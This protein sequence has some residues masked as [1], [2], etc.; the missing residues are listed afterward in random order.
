MSVTNYRHKK[1]FVLLVFIALFGV[2]YF[3]RTPSNDR[4]WSLDQQLL[5][6][7][8]FSEDEVHIFNIRNFTYQSISEYTPAYYDKKFDLNELKSVDYIVEPFG[9]MGAAHTFLSFGFNNG[10]YVAISV[11]IR[12]EVGESFSPILGLLRNYELMY[13]IA[14]ERD[15]VKLRTNYRKDTVYLY[16]VTVTIDKMRLLFVDMLTRANNLREEP[17]FYNT[18][19]STCTTNIAS[20][21]NDISPNKI[22]RDLRL[23]LPENSDEL[24]Y[25][26]GFIDNSVPLE[27]L[28]KKHL[29]NEKAELHAESPDFSKLIRE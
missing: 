14:D 24:A 28:R 25:E 4:E 20:H 13:V 6:Y 23:L 5:P 15:V 17:E 26:L 16:P 2:W 1:L 29:I 8:E 18:L 19:T 7:A 21:I 11:E 27:E 10:E 22:P 9:N 3:S 12:K